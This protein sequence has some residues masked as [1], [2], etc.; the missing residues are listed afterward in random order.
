MPWEGVVGGLKNFARLSGGTRMPR[1]YT[2]ARAT[3]WFFVEVFERG[4]G[5]EFVQHDLLTF[6]I[7]QAVNFL[8]RLT[9]TS[10]AG[11]QRRAAAR[12]AFPVLVIS[13]RSILAEL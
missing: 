11:T 10:K 3:N 6:V 7:Q 2:N 5:V 1:G 9:F 13:E 8:P 4:N 12:V